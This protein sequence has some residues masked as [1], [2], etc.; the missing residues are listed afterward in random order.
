MQ[1]T[2]IVESFDI[3]EL[4]KKNEVWIVWDKKHIE[5]VHRT[6]DGAEQF[7]KDI[8]EGMTTWYDNADNY[9]A[10]GPFKVDK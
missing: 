2:D 10:I 8:K 9:E 1:I 3:E 7:V 4:I 5:S 6:K